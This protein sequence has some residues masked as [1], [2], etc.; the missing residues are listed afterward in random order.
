MRFVYQRGHGDNLQT[1]ISLIPDG[2]RGEV[3]VKVECGREV[4]DIFKSEEDAVQF[5]KNTIME[6]LVKE[7]LVLLPNN[8]RRRKIGGKLRA[9][10]C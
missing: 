7:S 8:K 2:Y 5:A 6:R 3:Q 9:A 1:A 10:P 4:L